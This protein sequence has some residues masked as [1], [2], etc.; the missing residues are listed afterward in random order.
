MARGRGSPNA[1]QQTRVLKFKCLFAG[2]EQRLVD[3]GGQPGR[4]RSHEGGV[5][6]P[7]RGGEMVWTGA[8]G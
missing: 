7:R 3:A 4:T 6:E 8:E 1:R 5:E 2:N